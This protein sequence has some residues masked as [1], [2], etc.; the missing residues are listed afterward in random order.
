MSSIKNSIL[1]EIFGG[2]S[3]NRVALAQRLMVRTSTISLQVAGMMSAGIVKE[4]PESDPPVRQDRGRP[5]VSLAISSDAF[6]AI[7]MDLGRE[8]LRGVLIGGDGN[9][10]T[11]REKVQVW[12][13]ADQ[14]LKA[15][16]AMARNLI[17]D[18]PDKKKIVG[19]SFADPGL[20]DS[21]KNMSLGAINIP[22]W[23]NINIPEL[24]SEELDC[25]I[26]VVP[27]ARSKCVAELLK[28]SATGVENFLFIDMGV[29]IA[30]GMVCN[31]QL[32]SGSRGL[33]G[34]LGHTCVNPTGQLCSCG[35][36]GCLE[37]ECSGWAIVQNAQELLGDTPPTQS[38]LAKAS[39]L[40]AKTL[41]QAALSHDT[42][43][44]RILAQAGRALG[45]GLANLVNLLNP[46]LIVF[47]GG[48]SAA[49]EVLIGPAR[50][51]ILERCLA[52]AKENIRFEISRLDPDAGAWGGA[53]MVLKDFIAGNEW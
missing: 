20:V 39:P 9:V 19:A 50:Q 38:M 42:L 6:Y 1:S 40:S 29:G 17:K 31:G 12:D 49:G 35:A 41:V 3:V 11:R 21:E 13:H 10:I 8:H 25:K 52:P 37:A 46:E 51:V 33:A 22:G 28:G 43:A 27:S 48:L 18:V 44:Q 2:N 5:R 14:G 15:I 47:G 36:V 16:R 23:Q 45:I 34:E 7:G 26:L 32:L 24:L 30:A 4:L 53:L